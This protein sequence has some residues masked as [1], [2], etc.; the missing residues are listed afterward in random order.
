MLSH[1]HSEGELQT[2]NQLWRPAKTYRL[3]LFQEKPR[4]SEK[5]KENVMFYIHAIYNVIS[6]AFNSR[7]NELFCLFT[8]DLK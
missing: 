6:H 7:Y 1:V 8:G 5:K 2:V 4:H 3:F